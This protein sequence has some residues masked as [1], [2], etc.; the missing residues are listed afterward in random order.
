M[1]LPILAADPARRRG[2]RPLSGLLPVALP[3]GQVLKANKSSAEA[4]GSRP[5]A[6]RAGRRPVRRLDRPH[7]LHRRSSTPRP[8]MPA[9]SIPATGA[10][11]CSRSTNLEPPPADRARSQ[12]IADA[13]SSACPASSRSAR[14]GIG[15]AT[16]N[17]IQ[18][19]RPGARA[20]RA[21]DDRQLSRRSRILRDDGHR[22]ASPAACSTRTA[23]P[24]VTTDLSAD[25]PEAERG[26]RRAR[27]QYRHQRARGAAGSASRNP[28]EAVGKRS[29]V[30]ARSSPEHGWSRRR[31]IGV[32]QDTRFR[33]V[34][35]PIEPIMFIWHD[36]IRRH[37]AGP[38]RRSRS[39]T[40]C[41]SRVE[42]A[43]KRLAPDV[44]FDGRVQRGRSSPS[45]TTP[46]RRARRSSPASRCSP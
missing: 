14:P 10:T 35:E 1:L 25:D 6:Q 18:H 44:P 26:A 33:S 30:D 17:N 31:I 8:S 15:V 19:R 27:R 2:R 20:G 28:A 5:A 21:G 42:Q 40:R 7:H 34:R 29:R 22:A 24:T 38:L 39:R 16:Q 9:P 12:A 3:A 13:R 4:A 23:R 41:A 36:R 11:A 46:R 37:A 45:S 43:W 32:V